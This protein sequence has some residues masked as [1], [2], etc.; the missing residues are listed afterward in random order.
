M[1]SEWTNQS[2]SVNRTIYLTEASAIHRHDR[3]ISQQICVSSMCPICTDLRFPKLSLLLSCTR[4]T[5]VSKFK[6]RYINKSLP[7]WCSRCLKKR[8]DIRQRLWDGDTSRKIRRD[9]TIEWDGSV[10]PAYKT[11]KLHA[12]SRIRFERGR[13]RA[14]EYNVVLWS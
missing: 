12:I 11:V 13:Q 10:F 1:F 8:T 5:R 6:V 7:G 2:L 9:L 3:A 4:V 14:C